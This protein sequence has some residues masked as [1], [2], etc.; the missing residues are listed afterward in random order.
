MTSNPFF[1]DYVERAQEQLALFTLTDDKA[2]EFIQIS[3]EIIE[4]EPKFFIF[5]VLFRDLDAP[6]ESGSP[7]EYR[8]HGKRKFDP[9]VSKKVTENWNSKSIKNSFY[10]F[11]ESVEAKKIDL[12]NVEW[13][14][15]EAIKKQPE[16]QGIKDDLKRLQEMYQGMQSESDK[17]PE[18]S[19]EQKKLAEKAF[20]KLIFRYEVEYVPTDLAAS[21]V[22]Y[23]AWKLGKL[24]P[25]D[26]PE[27]DR[28]KFG[29]LMEALFVDTRSK[30]KPALFVEMAKNLGIKRLEKLDE[31][32]LSNGRVWQSNIKDREWFGIVETSLIHRFDLS[33]LDYYWIHY[34]LIIDGY[35]F[36]GFVYLVANTDVYSGQTPDK[37]PEFFQKNKYPKLYSNLKTI[38]ETLRFSLRFDALS[39]IP[40]LLEAG[41]SKQEIFIETVKDYFVCFDVR[42]SDIEEGNLDSIHSQNIYTG[43]G[44]KMYG[45]KWIRE[46]H[47]E[48]IKQE[49]EGGREVV[50]VSV[51]GLI[52]AINLAIKD[53]K[54]IKLQGRQ[55]QSSLFAHQAAGL[56]NEV[57]GDRKLRSDVHPQAKGCLWHLRS[58]IEI[59][60]DFDL[61]ARKSICDGAGSDFREKEFD[62]TL[63]LVNYFIDISLRHALRRASYRRAEETR[64]TQPLDERVKEVADGFLQNRDNVHHLE[65]FKSHLQWKSLEED[66]PDWFRTRGF[67]TCFHHCFWQSAYHAFRASCDTANP[68][69]LWI[70][71]PDEN[72]LT[73]FNRESLLRNRSENLRS[74]DADFYKLLE[75]K[76]DRFIEIKGPRQNSTEGYWEVSIC[77]LN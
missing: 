63:D 7:V 60:G 44:I 37:L 27:K 20:N 54:A 47:R 53:A 57:W 38:S 75:R 34:P 40:K 6:E 56:V 26:S 2:A 62:T 30:Q 16:I 29:R 18:L 41:K 65:Q 36:T 76:M 33:K 9:H 68:P 77:R 39:K 69:Y 59:N 66:L 12:Q 14:T 8:G 52:G 5:E 13:E 71:I 32:T 74:R 19:E 55:E 10:Q 15:E 31:S 48:K 67:I 51:P 22:I 17:K 45:P 21:A 64:E 24:L 23:E 43:N 42:Q 70:D 58:L 73:I 1:K 3:N 35:W 50:G 61:E 11:F 72:K 4:Y 49:L 28:K 46:I 25:L